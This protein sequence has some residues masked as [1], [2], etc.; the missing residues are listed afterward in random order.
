MG[1]LEINEK[2]AAA[3]RLG[4]AWRMLVE[5]SCI[6]KVRSNVPPPKATAIRPDARIRK[7]NV[8]AKSWES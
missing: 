4:L 5:L 1:E 3:A 8:A 7:S 2:G 6:V